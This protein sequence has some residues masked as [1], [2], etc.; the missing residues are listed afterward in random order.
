MFNSP[1]QKAIYELV[2]NWIKATIAGDTPAVLSLMTDDV[3]FM[4][5]GREP[6]GKETFAATSNAMKDFRI[7][8]RNDILEINVLRNTAWMRCQIQIT[9][10]PPDGQ[11]KTRAGYTLT[12]LEKTTDG[13]WLIKRDA[14]LVS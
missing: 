14:N 6:F 9:I 8:G 13:R 7:E 1:D 3:I 5:P 10:T 11:P 2:Q 4:V 12:I